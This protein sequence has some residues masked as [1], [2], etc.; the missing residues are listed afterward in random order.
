[1][2][3]FPPN[4][5]PRARGRRS[6]FV[7]PPPLGVLSQQAPEA[8]AGATA[9]LAHA[10]AADDGMAPNAAMAPLTAACLGDAQAVAA[11]L[12]AGGGVDAGCTERN[13]ATLLTT[14]AAGGHEGMVRMLLRRGA[15]VNLQ[16][17]DGLTALM[18]AA[19]FGHTTMVQ[20]L[21][22]AKADASLQDSTEMLAPI[23][24]LAPLLT[25]GRAR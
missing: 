10:A 8:E 13:G 24:I 1:M 12:D 25:A 16:A 19:T 7:G 22:D 21:F 9:S 5:S 15:S 2:C 20:V 4:F 11:W 18:A 14:A 17:S 23:E 6:A 3:L